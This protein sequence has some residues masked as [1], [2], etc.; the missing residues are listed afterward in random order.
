MKYKDGMFFS[1]QN[2]ISFGQSVV[3]SSMSF[4]Q[5]TSA[6]STGWLLDI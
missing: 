5:L 6:I 1:G 4:L 2:Q 3:I